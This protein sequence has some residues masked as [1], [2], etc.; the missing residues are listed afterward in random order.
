MVAFGMGID[1]KNM[2]Q[3]LHV[4]APE[5]IESYIQATGCAGAQSIAVLMQIKG[6][7]IVHADAQMK[8]YTSNDTECRR[9]HLFHDYVRYTYNTE[10]PCLCC[11]ICRR[12]NCIICDLKVPSFCV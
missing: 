12:C 1:C 9:Y 5:D 8:S 4:R 2:H 10:S 7:K 3:I 11:D 6:V